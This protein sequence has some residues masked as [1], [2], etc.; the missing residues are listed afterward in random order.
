M[1]DSSCRLST[2]TKV[3]LNDYRFI[4][5][6]YYRFTYVLCNSTTNQCKSM[7]VE[8]EKWK[9][10]NLTLIFS[11]KIKMVD[12]NSF[13][14]YN[15]AFKVLIRWMY[16]HRFGPREVKSYFHRYHKYITMVRKQVIEFAIWLDVKKS[17]YVKVLTMK[18]TAIE[19]HNSIKRFEYKIY[20]VLYE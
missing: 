3:K 20:N 11:L 15:E 6:K 9:R 8:E 17:K 13:V 19:G 7:K 10:V 2:I 14:T 4:G 5:G 16:R 1:I 18:M 12:I